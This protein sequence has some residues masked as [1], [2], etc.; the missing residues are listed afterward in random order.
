LSRRHVGRK[1]SQRG[2][3]LADIIA[4]AQAT[5]SAA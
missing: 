4:A 3:I 1:A 5:G 2:A